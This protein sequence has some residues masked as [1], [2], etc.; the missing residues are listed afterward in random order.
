MLQLLENLLLTW[1]KEIGL[2]CYMLTKGSHSI[3]TAL[4]IYLF[5]AVTPSRYKRYKR[6]IDF[7][8]YK[9]SILT[10]ENKELI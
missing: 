9:F 6:P 10:V 2:S 8:K 1:M 7:I 5:E 4:F 3:V